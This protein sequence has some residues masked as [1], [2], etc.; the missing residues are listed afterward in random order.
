MSE[1]RGRCLATTKAGTQCK[2]SAQDDSKY[3]YIHAKLEV[4]EEIVENPVVEEVLNE[5][6]TIEKVVIEEERVPPPGRFQAVVS[7]LNK[8]AERLQKQAPDFIPPP[9][10]PQELLNLLKKN[11]DHFTPEVVNDL[12]ASLEEATVEDF[13]DPDTWKG[14]WYIL[15]YSAKEES[16]SL[17]NK[18]TSK[19]SSIPGVNQGMKLLS[20]M[21]GAGLVSD[22]SEMLSEATPKD[23]LDKDT[24]AGMWYILNHSLQHEA[25]EMKK[26]IM[27]DKDD[28]ESAG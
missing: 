25:G 12:R 26:R 27:G 4:A 10:S 21:P 8:V 19:V 7:E 1:E 17:L 15:T 13:K 6:P 24:W 5:E 22:M 20:S 2:N 14:M 9:F 28:T 18:A 3:C 11:V 23:F 16:K